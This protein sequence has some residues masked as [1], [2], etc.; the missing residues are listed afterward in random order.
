VDTDV[1]SS[2]FYADTIDTS[3]EGLAWLEDSGLMW[4]AAVKDAR[5]KGVPVEENMANINVNME[6]FALSDTIYGRKELLVALRDAFTI[7][8]WFVLL[9][10]G[11]S[12]G[13][14]YVLE[15]LRNQYNS[16]NSASANADNETKRLVL[17]VD[18][19]RTAFELQNGLVSE[20]AK[21]SLNGLVSKPDEDDLVFALK[22][23]G[24]GGTVAAFEAMIKK[25]DS[26][27]SK[28]VKTALQPILNVSLGNLTKA[29]VQLGLL[30]IRTPI[31]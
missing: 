2:T 1:D 31:Q 29:R 25:F 3:R 21:L 19:R 15:T 5:D 4:E 7:K 23:V 22:R 12:V 8:G 14:S 26:A 24:R 20:I 18:G 11:K 27:A 9:R 16:D 30:E 17:Y 10:G 28:L 13:K 6:K